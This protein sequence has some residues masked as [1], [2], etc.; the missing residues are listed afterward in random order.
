MRKPPLLP[1]LLGLL[2]LTG[3]CPKVRADPAED[4]FKH[5]FDAL[6]IG[7]TQKEVATKLG[8]PTNAKSELE[9]TDE[10]VKSITGPIQIHKGDTNTIWVYT[11][12]KNEYSLWFTIRNAYDPLSGVLFKRNVSSA[13]N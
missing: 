8:N 13:G 10:T 4:A 3:T 7:M 1:F 12:G 5:K 6:R 2:I 11:S 9:E